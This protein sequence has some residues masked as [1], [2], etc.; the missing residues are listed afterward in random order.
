ML[1]TG[2]FRKKFPNLPLFQ[3]KEGEC[4]EV[5][6]SLSVPLLRCEEEKFDYNPVVSDYYLLHLEYKILTQQLD[7]ALTHYSPDQH[8]SIQQ[9]LKTALELNV[10]LEYLLL[11]CLIR[12]YEVAGLQKEKAFYKHLLASPS[13]EDWVMVDLP[14]FEKTRVHTPWLNQFRML[15]ARARRFLN[16]L[17]VLAENFARFKNF[18]SLM[19][20]YTNTIFTHLAWAFFLPRLLSNLYS[21]LK[22]TLPYDLK[23]KEKNLDPWVRFEAQINRLWF[24]LANDLVWVITGLCNAFLFTGPT[25]VYLS[26]AAFFFDIVAAMLKEY[27]ELN[28]LVTLQEE[29]IK[30]LQEES[31]SP[32]LI[33]NYQAFLERRKAFEERRLFLPVANTTAVFIA[34][35]TSL[36]VFASYP[37]IPLLGA[38]ALLAIW[39]VNYDLI[40]RLEKDPE[41]PIDTMNP[42]QYSFCQ[43][44]FAKSR[45]EQPEAASAE[46]VFSLT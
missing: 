15:V 12:S 43:G 14:L 28:R 35:C 33:K 9:L 11:D 30:A 27:I 5:D 23:G 46:H 24:E 21:V 20:Q 13:V 3:K 16:L 8:Q 44:F 36:P 39:V 10:L 2:T 6:L 32:Q 31:V 38:L 17:A 22:H 41:R 18:V 34:M 37:V 40:Q 7:N 19:D 25:A 45:K 42:Q 26:L 29:C 1:L 4:E